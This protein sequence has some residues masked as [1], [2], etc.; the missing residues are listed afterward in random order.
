MITPVVDVLIFLSVTFLLGLALGWI[1]WNFKPEAEADSAEDE[2]IFWKTRYNQARLESAA[3][4]SKI[5][6]LE[7]ELAN[8]KAAT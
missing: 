1:V 6:D 7:K 8:L 4:Q 2:E 5:S 3:D